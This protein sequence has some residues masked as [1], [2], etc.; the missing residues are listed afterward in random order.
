MSRCLTLI[1][2]ILAPVLGHGAAFTPG[3]IVVYRVGSGTGVLANTGNP[4]FLDEFTPGGT[5]VQSVALPTAVAGANKRCV[6]S[7]TAASEGY[8]QRST[9][10][11]YLV[12]TGYDSALPAAA[13]LAT[14]TAARVVA[15]ID[16][17][18]AIN[19]STALTDAATANNPRSAAS[20][21]GTAFWFGGG[22]G[23]VR[24]ALLGATTSTD[25]TTVAGL[26][27]VRMPGIFSGRLYAASQ[28]GTNTFKG[29]STVGSGLP[30]TTGQGVVRLSGL[31]DTNMAGA[32]MF[33]MADLST[34]V[35]GLDTL[36]TADENGVTGGLT[37]FCLVGG[38]WT[39]C[40]KI[41]VGADNYRGLTGKVAGTKVT[42]FATKSNSAQLVSLTDS[43]GYN[44]SFT[45]TPTLLSTASANTAYRG[46]ALAP[47]DILPDLTVAVTAPANA[48]TGVNFVYSIAV[49]N[50]GTSTAA[51]ASF[52]VTL[53]AGLSYV[54]ATGTHGFSASQAAGVVD[55][56][57]GSLPASA[58]A[59]L[60][61]TVNSASAATYTLAA[62]DAVADPTGSMAESIE[63]NNGSPAAAITVVTMPNTPPAFVLHPAGTTIGNGASTMLTAT[64]SGNP[65][66]TYQW[67]QGTSGNTTNPVSGATS[68][69]YTTPPLQIT[70]SYWVR[71]SN[72]QGTADSNTATVSVTPSTDAN[73]SALAVSG[74]LLSPVFSASVQSYVA[75]VSD[76]TASVTVTPTS[77]HPYAS[78]TVNSS[79]V[80]SGQSSGAL[81]VNEG[82]NTLTITVLAQDGV[83]SKTYTV[84]LIRSAPN[85]A[86]G[87][88][89]FIGWNADG[90][91]DLAFVALTDIP[92][93]TVIHFSDNEWNG[94][95][96]GSGGAFADFL[97]SEFA[98]MPP[99]G[100]LPGGSV[101]TI[102]SLSVTTV[103][104]TG[105]LYSTDN[106]ARGLS[107]TSD[108][109]YAFMG[110]SRSPA[111][112]LAG[113]STDSALQLTGTGLSTSSTCVALSSSSDGAVYTGTRSGQ[114]GY[115]NYLAFI[116][117]AGT[118]WNDVG[119]LDG[120]LLLPFSTASFSLASSPLYTSNNRDVISPNR[121]LWATGGVTL[122]GIQFVN[123]GLQGVGRIP[124]SLTDPVTGETVGSISD[125][126]LTGFIDNGNGSYS[127]TFHFLP[128]RGYSGGSADPNT[129]ARIN[130]FTFNFT[131]YTG[132]SITAAQNQIV[133]TFTG[134]TRFGY[135]HDGLPATQPAFTSGMTPTAVTTLFG[136]TMPVINQSTTQNGNTFGNRLTLTG[137]GLVLDKRPG[138]SGEGWVSD[139]YGP[140]ILHFDSSKQLVG[141]IGIPTA[142]IP[143]APAGNIDFGSTSPVSGRR[144]NQGFEGLAQSPDGT[145]LFAMLQS[146]T[147][148]D[149][150]SGA[151][152]RFNTRLLVYDISSTSTPASP[153]AQHVIQLPRID[154]T[155]S[156][157]N[158]TNVNRTGAQSA[159]LALNN[160]TL[161][162]LS[163][164][165]NGRGTAGAAPVFKSL[166]LLDLNGATNIHGLYD[167]EGA[168]ISP[169]GV[170]SPGVTP[171]SWT[172][173]LNLIGGLGSFPAE[174]AKFGLN[175]NAGNGN[176]HT[177]SDKWEGVSLVSCADAANPNDFF[178]FV[179]NDNNFQTTSGKYMLPHGALQIYNAGLAHD[180]MVLAY[181]VRIVAPEIHV[182]HLGGQVS[183]AQPTPVNIGTGLPG[184]AST[185]TFTIANNGTGQLT[186]LSI[187][188]DGTDA[189]DFS[190]ISSPVVPIS[191]GSSTSFTVRLLSNSTGNK[192][193]ALHIQSNTSGAAASFD[194]PLSGAVV[195]ATPYLNW[196][197]NHFG[198]A[199]NSGDAADLADFDHD[200]LPNLLEYALGTAPDGPDDHLSVPSGSVT[201]VKP[202]LSGRLSI[203]FQTADAT[204][205]DVIYT[206]QA[207][208]DLSTGTWTD[209]ATKTGTGV[210]TWIAGGTSR[211]LTSSSAGRTT[212]RV[213]DSQA[214]TPPHRLMR[215]KVDLP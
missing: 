6:A 48:S 129:A 89:A 90:E 46:V 145:R 96:V 179:G 142:I 32:N 60:T 38:T 75:F 183:D 215:V 135:D 34:S 2:A 43:S 83:T 91:D 98:W 149:S 51:S 4:V 87:A 188:I 15:R 134:S 13:S 97:E 45:G 65:A 56:T 18:G 140:A 152:G 194:I 176:T 8:L 185:K 118:N 19:S 148:Q 208:S 115:A 9:D 155:G 204:P 214:I 63:T 71:A 21:D 171:V 57:G 202:E 168:A 108:T 156:T 25:L 110:A 153:V 130:S 74:S 207:T 112:F 70:T 195:S 58:V 1:A 47:Q 172:Q 186:G 104:N 206:V 161:L 139:E 54:S 40:G 151:D 55:F 144:D 12:A 102:N 50:E 49:A 30:T 105:T 79:P 157:T 81:A 95:P 100:G 125:M 196:K 205:T 180:S 166:L 114:A 119:D 17:T 66:P 213:G 138:H 69:S 170:L 20:V 141:R 177:L 42:L 93:N 158:G 175:L 159:V 77:A 136:S 191:S 106:P 209:L 16:K 169:S 164:D 133:M 33:F 146:A 182:S 160:T 31:V 121:D 199:A 67:Y 211:I 109:V 167:S 78:I 94:L 162:V 187:S 122:N 3:N 28:N 154:D 73:L 84:N 26:V 44:A 147:V 64:A 88:I 210:W 24:Y 143:H 116:S 62:G 29:V 7:G 131:P 132:T 198:T 201:E 212:V 192:S 39:A 111:V 5:L 61:V 59:N 137:E 103:V 174:V 163:R 80:A 184:L 10:G 200:S 150:A 127:G 123:L 85:L 27:N 76:S 178:L 120:T 190:V 92:E 36:Y 14:T 101:V 193:A 53:P 86:P 22:T 124:S 113:I 126:Q 189:A 181:R 107:T 72:S 99:P 23:G 37:K 173:A 117:N 128:D 35:T 197:L 11:R 52:R 82:S 68:S 41:G 203:S 165:G